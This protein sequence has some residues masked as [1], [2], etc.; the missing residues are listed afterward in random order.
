MFSC[1]RCGIFKI[2]CL[3]EHLR[4]AA[5][6]RRYFDT[7][8][9]KQSGFGT[10]YSFKILVSERKYENNLKN[11]EFQKI[12]SENTGPVTRDHVNS[13]QMRNQT[14]LQHLNTFPSCQNRYNIYIF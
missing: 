12:H 6:I 5:Y 3:E 7:I 2:K 13:S 8:N 1:Q 10:T 9:L 4:T 14:P 11:G